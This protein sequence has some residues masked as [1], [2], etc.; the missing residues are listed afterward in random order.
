ME[1]RVNTEEIREEQCV[2]SSHWR[3]RADAGGLSERVISEQQL[4]GNENS[5]H[6]LGVGGR[7]SQN[8]DSCA[9]DKD[10]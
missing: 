1:I 2:R 7:P 10:R 5:T 9:F 3:Q 6:S 4:E 8:W